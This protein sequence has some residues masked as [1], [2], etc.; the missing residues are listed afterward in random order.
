MRSICQLTASHT[1]HLYLKFVDMRKSFQGLQGLIHASFGRYLSGAEVFVFVGKNRKT[2]KVFHREANGI[3]LYIRRL[4]NG[5]FKMP[6]W[7][8]ASASCRLN[9][10]EFVMMALGENVDTDRPIYMAEKVEKK[11]QKAENN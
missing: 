4:S 10:N 8:E 6:D 1:Y 9:Y 5:C 7:D 11:F 3:T 2:M